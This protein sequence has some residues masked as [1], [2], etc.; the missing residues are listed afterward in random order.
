VSNLCGGHSIS[1]L[2]VNLWGFLI[3]LRFTE[4]ICETFSLPL[5]I[6]LVQQSSSFTEDTHCS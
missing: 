2:L 1:F 3:F 5:S 4:L 6:E